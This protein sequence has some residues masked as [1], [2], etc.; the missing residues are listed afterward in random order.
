MTKISE[1]DLS[2]IKKLLLEEK[3]HL[4][5]ELAKVAIKNPDNPNIYEAKF[6]DIGN[7]ETETSSE[8]DQYTLNITLQE[9]LEKSLRDIE[10]T[11]KNIDTPSYGTCKYCHQPIDIKRLKA[12]PSSSACVSCKT[13]LKNL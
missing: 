7:E 10:K 11:L 5:K 9:T 3:N 2:E 12:R 4:E 6:E 8:V 13:K 1:K